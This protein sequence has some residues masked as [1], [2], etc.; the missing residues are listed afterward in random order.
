[1]RNEL[2]LTISSIKVQKFNKIFPLIE[3]FKKGT[4]YKEL[5]KPFLAE[6]RNEK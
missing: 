2:E 1:M 4:I 6:G 3:G 5:Y